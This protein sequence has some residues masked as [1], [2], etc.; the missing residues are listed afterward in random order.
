ME[1]SPYRTVR[2]PRLSIRFTLGAEDDP[3]TVEDADAV[4]TAPN[5]NRWTATLMTPARIATV[6]ERWSGTGE[7]LGGQ[8]FQVRDLVIVREGG[9]DSMV[10]ALEDIFRDYGT[11]TDVLPRLPHDDEDEEDLTE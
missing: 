4:I 2:T 6:M 7:C 11:D 3:H 9:L 1:S 8:Y 10:S 5:G